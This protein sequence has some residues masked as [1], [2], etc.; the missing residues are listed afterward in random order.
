MKS[1]D[2]EYSNEGNPDVL[3]F[4]KKPGEVLDIGCGVGDN[5]RILNG[6]GFKVDGITIAKA[7]LLSAQAHL[8]QVWLFDV[9]NG[10]PP[11]TL[12]KKYDYIICSHVLEHICYPDKLL[13][14]SLS[15]LKSNGIL[16][17]ALPNLMHYQSRLQLLKGNFNY[18]EAG[19]WDNTHFKW[20]TFSSGRKLLEEN[21]YEI[22][23]ADVTGQ[24]PANSIF[25]KFISKKLS[26]KIYNVLKSLSKG[27]FGYQLLYVAKSK[28]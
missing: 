1:S 16:I 23:I 4:F 19:I 12:E 15:I 8:R 13:K 10:L 21:G 25:S 20:Y 14:D 9:E 24:L 22:I 28:N 18:Q 3:K 26:L 2:K 5:A 17:I 11:E 6:N 7:E 27:L